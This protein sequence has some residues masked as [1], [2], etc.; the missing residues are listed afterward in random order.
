M[1][2]D[3]FE[4]YVAPD[5]RYFKTKDEFDKAISKDFILHANK[6][7]AKGEHFF[8]GLSHGKSPSGAYQYIIEHYTKITKPENI[9]YT[10]VNTPLVTQEGLS[11]VFDARVFLLTLLKKGYISKHQILGRNF[12]E[13]E[14]DDYCTEINLLISS[15]LKEHKKTGFDYAFLASNPDGRVAGI[16]RN[17]KAFSSNE[18]AI[19]VI[20]KKQKE[21]TV[22]PFFLKKSA[23]IAF[24]ATKSD[25]R[26]PLAWLYSIWGKED[27]SPSFLRFI[28]NVQ[29]KMTV[30]IDDQALTW[31]QIEVER[32]TPYGVSK[33]RIDL[34]NSYKPNVKEKLPVILL[35]HGF[36]GLN[37]FDALLAAIPSTKYIAAAMH[38][39]T[40]PNDLP[41]KEY[42]QH[43]M[44]NIDAVVSFFGSKG[45][46]VY[47]FDHSMGNIYFLMMDR[48]FD[49]LSGINTYLRGRIGANP[50]FGE[51]SKHALLGF[52]DNV[53][54]PSVSFLEKIAEKTVLLTFRSILPLDTKR[55]VRRRGINLTEVLIQNESK[56]T[57]AIWSAAKQRIM[58]LMSNMDSLPDLNRIPIENALNR[59]PSKIFAIQI[60]SALQESKAFDEQ[61]G[62]L[63]TRIHKIP[64]LILKSDKD[65]VAKFV[66]RLYDSENA[67]IMDITNRQET[68]LFREHL[69]HMV[70]PLSTTKIIDAFITK[71][72]QELNTENSPA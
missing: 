46:P 54:I 27:E 44:K 60:N 67:K 16:E 38:Y 51:E 43:V 9:R 55:G 28:D 57:D 56:R 45:H 19:S 35:V 1:S 52:L 68:D 32:E 49:K 33:I 58:F 47:L 13:E 5:T 22:T 66:P 31:P 62:L 4:V 37:S 15:Y 23:R 59:L 48:E 8:V 14:A 26:R 53:I 2:L 41:V 18:V 20:V 10:F 36:L 64:V 39:G 17:S 25:K 70:N 34:A 3:P 63:H 24:L 42:S 30:F 72:E 29:Q 6:T 12:K 40:I 71:R 69:Y 50:F 7:L 61:T 11:D 65:G 21:I